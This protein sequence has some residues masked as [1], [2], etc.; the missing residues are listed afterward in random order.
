MSI[1]CIIKI[2]SILRSFAEQNE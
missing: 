1:F 2:Y